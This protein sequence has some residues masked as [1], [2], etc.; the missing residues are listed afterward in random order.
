MEGT[1]RKLSS[2][3]TDTLGCD[4][5]HGFTYIDHVSTCQITPITFRTDTMRTLTTQCRADH[6]GRNAGLINFFHGI[7]INK[8]AIGNNTLPSVGVD[9]IS[10]GD[11]TKDSFTQFFS[12]F[13]ALD[14]G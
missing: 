5:S 12:D 4:N 13:T 1:H 3:F 14:H 7:F 8:S 6:N 11:P 2:R 9:D 10:H